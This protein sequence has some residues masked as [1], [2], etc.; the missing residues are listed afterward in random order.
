MDDYPR[1]WAEFEARFST[2]EAC[3][4]YLWQLRWPKGFVCP[5]CQGTKTW[6]HRTTLRRCAACDYQISVTAGTV[7]Q[8][9]HQPLTTWFRAMWYVTSQK[10]GGSALGMQRVLGLKSYQTAWA[11]LH[12]LRRAM[13]RPGRDRVAGWVEV[14]ETYL[15]G[16]EEGVSG[17][18]HG[19]K[20]LIVVAAQADGKRIGRIRLR[21]IPD[22]SAE[23][24]HPFVRDCIAPGSTVHTDGWSGYQGLDQLGYDHEVTVLRGK[25]KDAG[26]LLPRVHLVVALLKRWLIGTHQG[27]VSHKHLAYYLDEFTFR[28]NRRRSK[29]R[30]LL[31][32]RLVEQAVATAPAPTPPWSIARA[33]PPPSDTSQKAIIRQKSGRGVKWISS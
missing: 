22:A 27:A 26:K 8:D 12:K 33:L 6:P 1:T 29:S 28:F 25:R 5:R 14:D 18:Q 4:E 10:N 30:G 24:L 17:R 2:D 19:D 15:G 7:F 23:S 13:V 3:R 16:L 31:F 20:A 9:T 21:A 11:W 32:F